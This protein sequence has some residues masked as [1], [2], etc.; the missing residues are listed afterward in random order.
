MDITNTRRRRHTMLMIEVLPPIKTKNRYE[1]RC[2]LKGKDFNFHEAVYRCKSVIKGYGSLTESV[3]RFGYISKNF[4]IKHSE[5]W[6]SIYPLC[7]LTRNGGPLY[8]TKYNQAQI[9]FKYPI[10]EKV[11][12]FYIER[13]ANF[14]LSIDVEGPT[15][16][17][18]FE[19]PT[20]GTVLAFGG[21]KD[22]RMLLGLLEETG[23]D[24]EI[25]TAGEENVPDIKKAKIVRA[26]SGRLLDRIMPALMS[27]SKTFMNGCG[28]GEAVLTHPWMAYYDWGSPRSL[29]EFSSL[30]ESLGVSIKLQAPVC[31]L[32]SNVIQEIL[33]KRYPHL[34]KYQLSVPNP[35]LFKYRQGVPIEK[36]LHVSLCKI[37]HGIDFT[38]HCSEKLFKRL[39]KIFVSDQLKILETSGF[40]PH[41]EYFDREMRCITFRMREH[42]LFREV[43]GLIPDDWNDNWIDCIHTYVYPEINPAFLKIYKEY[44][45][46]VS[47]LPT[48]DN[49]YRIAI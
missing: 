44:A 10:L 25:Y 48:K 22:S 27:G 9:R 42:S 24:P 28:L 49:S 16:D 17:R 37:Y 35:R 31:I 30:M 8:G 2:I 18:S 40:L 12:K 7:F 4:E 20:N 46:E 43:R 34:Y 11:R 39:L 32:P 6:D 3:I 23:Y 33:F 21:G 47:R 13:A 38:E 19:I 36:N 41:R 15:Y 45:P 26:I 29:Q 5:M 14:G 1:F